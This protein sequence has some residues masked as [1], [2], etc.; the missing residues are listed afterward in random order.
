MAEQDFPK[1]EPQEEATASPQTNAPAVNVASKNWK[2]DFALS[3]KMAPMP[4][5]NWKVQA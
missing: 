4:A 2:A 5:K 1:D 3:K